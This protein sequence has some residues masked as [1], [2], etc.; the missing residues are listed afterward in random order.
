MSNLGGYQTIVTVAKK[1]GGPKNFVITLVG[2]GILGG[3]ALG[4]SGAKTFPKAK[5]W[6]LT[7]IKRKEIQYLAN[8]RT[9]IVS[10]ESTDT[11]GIKLAPGDKYKILS[12]DDDAVMIEKLGDKNNPYVVS[13]ELLGKI[14]DFDISDFDID[15]NSQDKGDK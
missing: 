8:G 1:L 5:K 12:R 7:R 6:L 4:L 9:F 15:E 3:V 11:D 13:V 10:G 2:G 14:S